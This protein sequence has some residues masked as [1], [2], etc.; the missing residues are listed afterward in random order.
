MASSTLTGVLRT[1]LGLSLI[2]AG[3]AKVTQQ[4][5]MLESAEHLG[6]SPE[7]Y[8]AI[9]AA[10]IAGGVGLL[11]GAKSKLIGIAANVGAV[12]VLTGAV[13]EHLRAGD[14]PDV[15]A[16]AAVLDA[17]AIVTLTRQLGELGR[18]DN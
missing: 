10:E 1:G 4:D 12:A 18:K 3:T 6:Y 11:A 16:P 13:V 7:S 9:G 15:Y 14:G 5:A 2:G 17:L 8:Q